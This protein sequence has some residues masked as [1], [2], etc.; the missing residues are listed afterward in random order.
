MPIPDDIAARAQYFNSLTPNN[1]PFQPWVN[2]QAN[3]NFTSD[4]LPAL[5][6]QPTVQAQVDAAAINDPQLPSTLQMAWSLTE[7]VK[8]MMLLATTK[9]QF[10]STPQ[11]TKDRMDIC[12]SCE[13]FR[14]NDSGRC[15]KCGCY[16]NFK[17]RL[18]ASKCPVNKW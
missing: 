11:D 12:T 13:F 14:A 8:N 1:S 3:P 4:A 18:A 17:A 2:E 5:S 6:S 10:M 15:V 7:Q 9:G 16:M